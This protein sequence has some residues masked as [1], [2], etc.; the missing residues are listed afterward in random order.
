MTRI[1]DPSPRTGT[2]EGDLRYG[3][4]LGT[5]PDK[6]RD[7]SADR[8]DGIARNV[9]VA[10]LILVP[11]RDPSVWRKDPRVKEAKKHLD[12]SQHGVNYLLQSFQE[13]MNHL[14]AD[15]HIT[16]GRQRM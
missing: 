12:N 16:V 10:P 4:A 13:S 15:M 6:H 9:P 8:V 7:F 11:A 1:S 14:R 2:F 5:H 3:R